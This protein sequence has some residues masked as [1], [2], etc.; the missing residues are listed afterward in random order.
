MNLRRTL[1]IAWKESLHIRRDPRSL[2]LAV[3]IPMLMIVLFGY[4]LTL[5]VDRVPLTIRDQSNSVASR[6]LASRFTAS[7]Y[8]RFVG[9][10]RSPNEAALAAESAERADYGEQPA[11]AGACVHQVSQSRKD[12][13]GLTRPFYGSSTSPGTAG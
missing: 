1:A 2:I 3:G 10:A 5:D 4:A 7:R 13:P 11:D 9:A 12:R 6:D 8:F